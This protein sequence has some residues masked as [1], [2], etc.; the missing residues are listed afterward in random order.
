MRV[1]CPETPENDDARILELSMAADLYQVSKRSLT[2]LNITFTRAVRPC[3]GD[4]G[5]DS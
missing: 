5:R 3:R 1:L 2:T 4:V